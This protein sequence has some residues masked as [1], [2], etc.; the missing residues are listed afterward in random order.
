MDYNV[1]TTQLLQV[2][3]MDIPVVFVHINPIQ[4]A[5]SASSCFRG[6]KGTKLRWFFWGVAF[7]LGMIVDA[8]N[9]KSLGQHF[10]LFSP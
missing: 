3:W 2:P 1:L 9:V 8:V 10:G 6:D 5:T 7:F 4:A